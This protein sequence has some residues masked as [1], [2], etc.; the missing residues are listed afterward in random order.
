[1]RWAWRSWLAGCVSYAKNAFESWESRPCTPIAAGGDGVAQVSS[2]P[3]SNSFRTSSDGKTVNVD[4]YATL[5]LGTRSGSPVNAHANGRRLDL[6]SQG[7][8]PIT[9]RPGESLAATFGTDLSA[10]FAGNITA[11]RLVGRWFCHGSIYIDR[12]IDS[13]HGRNCRRSSRNIRGP[14]RLW[15]LWTC[16]ENMQWTAFRYPSRM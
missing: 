8:V 16:N 11:K 3:I 7:G 6:V 9:I 14:N 10:T 4:Q 13:G 15:K 2:N 5:D 12:R 1:M